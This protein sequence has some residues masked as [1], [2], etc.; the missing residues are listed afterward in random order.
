MS[1]IGEKGK[2]S[3]VDRVIEVKMYDNFY[4]PNEF[5]IKKNETIKFIV[6]NYGELV[7]EFNIATKEMHLKHQPE[8]MKLVENE[9]L[10]ADK[11]DKKKM[12]EMAKKDHSMSHSHA[13]SVLLEPNEDGEIIWKFNTEAKLEAACNIP[14]HYETGMIAKIKY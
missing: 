6:H 8:M 11:I 5:K 4:E 9:I 10:L 14:D 12:K 1:M 13:N 7:H 3:E 2:L